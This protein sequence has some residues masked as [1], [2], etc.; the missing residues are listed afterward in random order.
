VFTLTSHFQ[1]LS[2]LV[3]FFA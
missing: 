1:A 3:A 2:H